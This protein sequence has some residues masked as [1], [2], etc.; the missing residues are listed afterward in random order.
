MRRRPAQRNASHR[1]KNANT[2]VTNVAQPRSCDPGAESVIQRRALKR[3]LNPPNQ[4]VARPNLVLGRSVRRTQ[5]KASQQAQNA[6]TTVTK[7]AQ[8]L[9]LEPG[10]APVTQR[11]AA[12]PGAWAERPHR[13]GPDRTKLWELDHNK[14]TGTFTVHRSISLALCLVK[15]DARTRVDA[16]GMGGPARVLNQVGRQH[17]AATKARGG[18]IG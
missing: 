11:S 4:S 15:P 1:A 16:G 7:V 5:R 6:K 12:Q 8:P 13:A 14:V 2:M 3:T 17:W 9:S 10:A 18:A